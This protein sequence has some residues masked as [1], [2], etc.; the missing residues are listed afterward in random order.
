MLFA[1]VKTRTFAGTR[2][3]FISGAPDNIKEWYCEDGKFIQ[4]L[5][6][7]NAVINA[8]AVNQ[9]GVLV[10]GADNGTM[11]FWDYRTG[12]RFQQMDTIVQPGSLDSEA[13]IYAMQF[14]KSGSRLITCEA[15]KTIK[16]YK[17]DPNSVRRVLNVP[18]PVCR[19][20]AFICRLR[21]GGKA[22]CAPALPTNA[23]MHVC[24]RPLVFFVCVRRR[25]KRTLWSGNQ[26]SSSDQGSEVQSLG[27][28]MSKVKVINFFIDVVEN[29]KPGF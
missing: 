10:S 4:N 1:L 28:G 6:G 19:A 18:L 5:S 16:M 21:N 20:C 17:E 9:D 8:L 26:L 27:V 23:Q 7:H 3:T 29:Q 15:D 12:H 25:R 14:D 11:S 2:N 22:G 24:Q 13:G